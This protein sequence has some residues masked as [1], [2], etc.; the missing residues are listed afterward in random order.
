MSK[1]NEIYPHLVEI[2]CKACELE[3]NNCMYCSFGLEEFLRCEVIP[4]DCA[5][6]FNIRNELKK[7]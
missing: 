3:C 1:I 4:K 5:L 7:G 2:S 6:L